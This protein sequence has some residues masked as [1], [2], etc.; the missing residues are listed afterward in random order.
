MGASFSTP[1][2]STV[3]WTEVLHCQSR[4]LLP[5]C[6]EA[7]W[8]QSR[9]NVSVVKTQGWKELYA[10]ERNGLCWSRSQGA[11]KIKQSAQQ[12]TSDSPPFFCEAWFVRF[13]KPYIICLPLP[14][15]LIIMW[16]LMNECVHQWV[17]ISTEEPHCSRRNERL[18]RL[19]A[20]L[21]VTAQTH[22][23][24]HTLKS[25]SWVPTIPN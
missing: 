20:K 8:F 5:E 3:Y 14:V 16:M 7:K 24:T 9:N 10:N 21:P 18:P 19:G 23:H 6:D 2:L 22:P 13:T 1:L 15:E 25:H 11:Q 4:L 12:S 17:E